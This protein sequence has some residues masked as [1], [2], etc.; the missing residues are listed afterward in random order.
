MIFACSSAAMRNSVA[1]SF[2]SRERSSASISAAVFPV[3]HTMKMNPKR[4]K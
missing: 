1:R 4:L 3:A 2:C